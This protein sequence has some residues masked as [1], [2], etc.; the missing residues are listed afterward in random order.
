MAW[1]LDEQL[2]KLNLIVFAIIAIFAISLT[3]LI[4]KTVTYFSLILTQPVF[5]FIID[6]LRYWHTKLTISSV[7]SLS[8]L[9]FGCFD[10]LHILTFDGHQLMYVKF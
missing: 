6:E 7:Y 8:R 2:F 10:L 1:Q 4:K 5:N 3:F 9:R